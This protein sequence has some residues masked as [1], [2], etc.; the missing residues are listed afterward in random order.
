M[1]GIAGYL[2]RSF[3]KLAKDPRWL[4]DLRDQIRAPNASG[5][6][7]ARLAVLRLEEKFEDLM[8]AHM[9]VSIITNSDIRSAAAEIADA[10]LSLE[11]ELSMDVA[12]GNAEHDAVIELLR[13]Y[14]WQ[15]REEVLEFAKLC[16]LSV[17]DGNTSALY[18]S[19]AIERVLQANDRL[20][21]RGRDSAG[22][23]IHLDVPRSSFDGLSQSTLDLLE[24]RN[25]VAATDPETVFSFPAIEGVV[26]VTFIKKTANLIGSLGDN[27][28]KL[29]QL[30]RRDILLWELA[31]RA[32]SCSVLAHTRWASSGTISI[33]NCHPHHAALS[34]E[35]AVSLESAAVF[36]LNGDV[37]NH[38]TLV[39]EAIVG[40]GKSI[41]PRVTTDA[42]VI[43]VLF[44]LDESHDLFTRF[45]SVF[46][47]L[48]GSMAIAAMGPLI[49]DAAFLAQKGSGQTLYASRLPD[50]WMFAS[51]GYGLASVARSTFTLADDDGEGICVKLGAESDL[52]VASR[53]GGGHPAVAMQPSSIR[54]F[55]RDIFR[56]EH[57]YF[58]QKEVHD[59]PS[60]VAKTLL[61]RYRW[62][63]D[64]VSFDGLQTDI[65]ESLRNRLAKGLNQIY[66]VGQGT[67]GVAAVGIAAL[68]EA[69]VCARNRSAVK[70][71][72]MRSSELS[73]DI[74]R[75]DF[76][77]ALLIAVSQSGTTTDTNRAVDLAR[78]RGVF[79]H[80]I[81]NRRGS[82]LVRKSHSTLYTSDGRDVEM[83]VAS[84]KAYY[85]QIAAGKLTALFLADTLRS[86]SKSEI[87]MEMI[88]LEALP[89]RISEVLEYEQ[90]IAKCAAEVAP[91]SRY[92]AVTGSGANYLAALE[93]RIKLSELCYKSIPVDFT[94]DKKH[95]D[96]ST[97]PLTLVIANDVPPALLGDVQKEIA[98]FKAHNGRPIVFATRGPE[99][100]SFATDA[101]RVI[102]LPRM[103]SGLAFV[104]A[105][106][107]GHLFG[108]HAALAIDAA[109]QQLK[110]IS[111]D[112]ER[113]ILD[114]SPDA[115]AGGTKKLRDVILN[116]AAGNLDSGLSARYIGRICNATFAIEKCVT[117]PWSNDTSTVIRDALGVLR[118]AIEELSRPVD[119]IRHQA[120]TVTVGT[121]RPQD[122]IAPAV[123]RA[124]ERVGLK[125][126]QMSTDDRK[127]VS[128]VSHMVDEVLWHT[129]FSI[130]RKESS[131]IL[132]LV[133]E[134]HSGLPRRIEALGVLGQALDEG[135]TQAGHFLETPILIIPLRGEETANI[136]GLAVLA[137]KMLV[138]ASLE[139][140][141]ASMKNLRQYRAKLREWEDVFGRDGENQLYGAVAGTAPVD[142]LFNS[143]Y[144]LPDASNLRKLKA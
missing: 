72:A 66:V 38:L 89:D 95:I 128:S 53:V 54:I 90:E 103:G 62:V 144:F 97:E 30:I 63:D 87:R 16:A 29:R 31:C 51:E 126:H 4:F 75:F 112:L 55:S 48:D 36:A 73:A 143:P 86:L 76:R 45:R 28:D 47:R 106:V 24:A 25:I 69:A 119:T 35:N 14:G 65:W 49:S 32:E 85:S 64:D 37:D 23:S 81:V 58:L 133:G 130:D 82:D 27:G 60:S 125:E 105:T 2:S 1:C 131:P 22:I 61:G 74:D 41:D 5:P 52:P 71:V 46:G 80:A 114:E 124:L 7:I 129:M 96:L 77:D 139:Q 136:E 120:K 127:A 138:S 84:T 83:S 101:E 19:H 9:L 17:P 110:L 113:A 99:A 118:E 123:A 104:L 70:V 108:L 79:V 26:K 135:I 43:P 117:T 50:G 6:E 116:A 102:A 98:I 94:E 134:V 56:G 137:L 18:V 92:W 107:A 100:E 93:V 42:K 8:S 59:G 91:R 39:R 13:D 78:E 44:R 142:L 132:E 121:S 33:A 21:V 115:V 20:E 11:N 67:A 12:R 68:I 3:A 10:L 88:D 40:R 140:K 111:A 57:G 141:L 34:G 15:L 122:S 109:A